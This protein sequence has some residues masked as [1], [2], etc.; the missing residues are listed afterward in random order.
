MS[1]RAE[2]EALADAIAGVE[3]E[4]RWAGLLRI[5]PDSFLPEG[6]D[7]LERE[8]RAI[9]AA[10]AREALERLGAFAEDVARQWGYVSGGAIS[11]GG[12]S[13]LEDAFEIL[14][15]DDPRPLEEG[16]PALCDEPGCGVANSSGWPSPSGYRH[17]CH[18]HSDLH[19]QLRCTWPADSDH[20][21]ARAS[22]GGR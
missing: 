19:A 9:E 18:W 12:L 17:T 7:A 8:V 13:V 2:S 11:A 20:R 3:L 15:W 4:R 1:G 21:A 16:D 5:L 6:W 14:G 22:D 10:A